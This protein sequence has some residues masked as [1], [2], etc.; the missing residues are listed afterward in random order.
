MICY[1]KWKYH[2]TLPARTVADQTA[3]AALG[4]GWVDHPSQLP[5]DDI[6]TDAGAGGP[7]QSAD[8]RKR[9]GRKDRQ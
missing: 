6:P 5:A 3:E 1:P 9:Q 2:R 4:S 7:V 8:A